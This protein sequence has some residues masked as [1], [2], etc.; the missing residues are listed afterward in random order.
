MWSIFPLRC[1][2]N[3]VPKLTSAEINEK[4]SELSTIRSRATFSSGNYFTKG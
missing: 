4:S 3:K 2:D 1:S